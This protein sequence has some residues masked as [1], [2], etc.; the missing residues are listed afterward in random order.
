[1]KYIR[2][3]KEQKH[4]TTYSCVYACCLKSSQASDVF[5]TCKAVLA[6]MS[7][8]GLC[9]KRLLRCEA[10]AHFQGGH[11]WDFAVIILTFAL[12]LLLRVAL[13]DCHATSLQ[14]SISHHPSCFHFSLKI[15]R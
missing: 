9:L 4:K 1:M 5:D 11:K 3:V 12:S 13:S 2:S 7:F 15:N 10:A 8:P 6:Q 14:E